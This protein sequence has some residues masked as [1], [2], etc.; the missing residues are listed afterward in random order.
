MRYALMTALLVGLLAPI[1]G[2]Q[3]DAPTWNRGKEKT[4]ADLATRWWK[5]RPKTKFVEWDQAARLSLQKEAEAL[6]AIPEGKLEDV[7]KAIWKSAKKYGP[8]HDRGNT[9]DTPYG[10]VPLTHHYLRGRE[11]DEVVV[12]SFDGR[13]WREPNPL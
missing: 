13:C 2:G 3:E 4:A 6:G 8:R 10:K 5:A 7:V 1:A 12:E 9:I 11:G